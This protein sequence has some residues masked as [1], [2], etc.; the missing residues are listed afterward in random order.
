MLDTPMRRLV[1]SLL[2]LPLLVAACTSSQPST[3]VLAQG[4]P[5]ERPADTQLAIQ[6]TTLPLKLDDP[7][8][9]EVGRLKWRGGVSLTA[10]SRDFGGWSDLQVAPDGSSLR[11]IS[12]VG[13]WLT[14]DI[15]YDAGG[16]LAGLARGRIGP[17][18]GPNGKPLPNKMEADAESMARLPDGSWLVGFEQ[19]HRILRY[20][21]GDEAAGQGLAGTPHLLEGPPQLAR[22]PGNGGLE[23]MTALP[24]GRVL[25][26]S[27]EYS[28]Q[29]GTTMGWIGEPVGDGFRW[30]TFNY[31]TI[32]DF[33]MTA[34]TSL[35]DGS[36]VTLERA[37]DVIRGVRVRVM[38]FTMDQL[39][40]GR[41]LQAE[42]LARLYVPYAV[43]N[44][45]GISATR[46]PRG[47]TLLWLMS[48]N[49]FN[50][51]QRTILLLFEL[52]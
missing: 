8:A 42:E 28:E 14:A 19:R 29:A 22:Q 37:F 23:A 32:P 40:P 49:N 50:P 20:P 39:K 1:R 21:A 27:E 7:A 48:D 15:V 6:A 16:N 47:E 25:M 35:P 38:R 43:D 30:L 4:K 45:E 12:D 10:N 5:A 26:L 34:I 11:S 24:D 52:K 41:T 46:G 51:L 17:L 13:S 36:F 18:H 44:L 9:S 33:R 3:R 31:A 2:V